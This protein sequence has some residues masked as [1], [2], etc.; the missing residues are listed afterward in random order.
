[1]R[2][3]F[4][5]YWDYTTSWAFGVNLYYWWIPQIYTSTALAD[6]TR[7]GNFLT[8]TLSALYHF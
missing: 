6:Q 5:A 3:G 7:Y 8:I 4:G 2:P 1:M